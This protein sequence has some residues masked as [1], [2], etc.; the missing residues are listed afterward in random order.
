MITAGSVGLSTDVM[1]FF[2]GETAKRRPLDD[3]VRRLEAE[4]FDLVAV[5][6]VLLADPLWIV[7][8]RAGR[9][10]EMSDLKP[11]QIMSWV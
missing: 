3:L 8:I 11:E 1:S 9:E 2:H 6:R 10:H 7:K 5:G 4:Q